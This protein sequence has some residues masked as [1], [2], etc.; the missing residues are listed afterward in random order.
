MGLKQ[1]IE[2]VKMSFRNRKMCKKYP[3]IIRKRFVGWKGDEEV[4]KYYHPRYAFTELDAIPK[5]WRT[6]LAVPLCEALLE[7]C[8]KHNCPPEK[9]KLLEIKEKYGGLRIDACSVPNEVFEDIDEVLSAFEVISENVCIGCGKLD[10]PMI[11]GGWISPW[12]KECY[13]K[14]GLKYDENKDP[15]R[16]IQDKYEVRGSNGTYVKDISKY[17]ESVRNY[18]T[19]RGANDLLGQCSNDKTVR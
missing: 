18:N 13:E 12:C 8:N 17:V 14:V 1:Y 2:D 6:A 7:V 5:G 4:Y 9:L 15:E 19:W 3:F 10:V 11:N 16:F